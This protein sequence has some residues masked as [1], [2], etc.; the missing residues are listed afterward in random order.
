M[1]YFD[2]VAENYES[3]DSWKQVEEVI[4][5]VIEDGGVLEDIQAYNRSNPTN[6]ITGEII[7]K[8]MRQKQ[9]ARLKKERGLALSRNDE[10]LR[11]LG[12]FGSYKPILLNQCR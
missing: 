3:A 9:K 6:A 10:H 8:S 7:L 1:S 11:M 2:R 5:H 4:S 12:R